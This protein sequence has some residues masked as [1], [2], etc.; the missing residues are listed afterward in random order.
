M[1]KK[2]EDDDSC[3]GSVQR[4][5]LVLS[6]VEE[7]E[8]ERNSNCDEGKQQIHQKVDVDAFRSLI[9][10]CKHSTYHSPGNSRER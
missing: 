8:E 6:K 10:Y 2:E 9:G 3:D 1:E 7:P 4:P 5:L